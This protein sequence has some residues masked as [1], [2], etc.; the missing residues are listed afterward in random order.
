MKIEKILDSK[1]L[2][3]DLEE[4][5]LTTIGDEVVTGFDIDVASLS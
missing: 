1:N 4:K 3:E 5:Q 2:I